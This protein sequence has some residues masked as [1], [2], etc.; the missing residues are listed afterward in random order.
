MQATWSDQLDPLRFSLPVLPSTRLKPQRS[1]SFVEERN[2]D[3][4]EI[5]RS[6]QTLPPVFLPNV[7]PEDEDID[8]ED[9]EE[10]PISQTFSCHV[11][12]VTFPNGTQT[13]VVVDEED[14]TLRQIRRQLEKEKSTSALMF[15]YKVGP[16]EV[17]VA[18]EQEDMLLKDLIMSTNLRASVRDES[19][20]LSLVSAKTEDYTL[21]SDNE[22][23]RE[24][25]HT[26]GL[27]EG[28]I[29]DRL[30]LF[31]QGRVD[32][33]ESELVFLSMDGTLDFRVKLN[34][35]RKLQ[36]LE[37]EPNTVVLV[38]MQSTGIQDTAVRFLSDQGCSQ[39][40]KQALPFIYAMAASGHVLETRTLETRASESRHYF[41][42]KVNHYGF[43][44]K[45]LIWLELLN[46][47][48]HIS[49]L[50]MKNHKIYEMRRLAHFVRRGDQEKKLSIIFKEGSNQKDLHL[51]FS[52]LEELDEFFAIAEES[53]MLKLDS[54]LQMKKT[55][56]FTQQLSSVRK[57]GKSQRKYSWL[58]AESTEIVTHMSEFEYLFNVV[59]DS[60]LGYDRRIIALNHREATMS[61]LSSEGKTL[62]TVPFT[63]ILDLNHDLE[64][65]R[66]LTLTDERA[67]KHVLIFSSV[68]LKLLFC[69]VVYIVTRPEL[70]VSAAQETVFQSELR[71]MVGTWNLGH[72][73]PEKDSLQDWVKNPEQLDLVALGF[74][75]C[76]KSKRAKWLQSLTAY[77]EGNGLKLLSFTPMWEMFIVIYARKT[78]VISHLATTAKATGIANMIGNKGGCV[79]TFMVQ[80]TSFCFVSCH[81]A[82]QPQRILTRNQNA[83]DLFSIRFAHNDLDF[84]TEFDYLFW[85]GDL[86]Y[87]VDKEFH[88]AVAML[89]KG[90]YGQLQVCDQLLKEQSANRCFVNFHEGPLSFPPTYR[91]GRHSNEWSNKR[92]QT[93]SWTDRVLYRSFKEV[94]LVRYEAALNCM[95]SDH[96]PVSAEF[97]V[98]VCPPFIPA[99]LPKPGEDPLFAVI[100]FDELEIACDDPISSTHGQ[101]VFFAPFLQ[102]TPSTTQF[103]LTGPEIKHT[104]QEKEIPI[105]TS[106]M[107]DLRYLREQ[108]VILILYLSS[109]DRTEVGGLASVPLASLCASALQTTPLDV[110]STFISDVF[111][112]IEAA[113]ESNGRCVGSVHG[114]WNFSLC[115]KSQQDH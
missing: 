89:D 86:N 80:E 103:S 10:R 37:G 106:A 62:K 69:R 57:P 38:C 24:Y 73:C 9:Y 19:L 63:S 46:F 102:S 110:R 26:W 88:T 13:S 36:L 78:L 27:V 1:K 81:L 44:Q 97:L 34:D 91:Y 11:V 98:K 87:R 47:K 60:F 112:D 20:Y 16:Q 43:K 15:S 94:S 90:L 75:E 31:H 23:M 96:R 104:L 107:T 82:A 68:Y 76:A 70:V 42:R 39:F 77:M 101:I 21:K 40:V 95:G 115:H 5:L 32:F 6:L 99:S 100:E 53:L 111:L 56:F 2:C 41:V 71:L 83:K 25:V 93:P 17:T 59:V 8:E 72:I 85:F 92:D 18:T 51:I 3:F 48:L 33:Y 64:D 28:E 52:S 35:I 49:D 105:L 45:R 54:K 79:A 108:R 84:T 114:R 50:T 4:G 113:L 58:S 12:S 22:I 109:K 66:R 61:V 74:Q 7:F 29:Q 30:F 65:L 55:L 14:Q 67:E